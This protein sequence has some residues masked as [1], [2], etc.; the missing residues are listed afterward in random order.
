[1]ISEGIAHGSIRLCDCLPMDLED[2]ICCCGKLW[3]A[4][5]ESESLF[6]FCGCPGRRAHTAGLGNLLLQTQAGLEIAVFVPGAGAEVSAWKGSGLAGFVVGGRDG[7]KGSDWDATSG[8]ESEIAVL[9][10]EGRADR[11]WCWAVGT[12]ER[13][14]CNGGAVAAIEGR[15][16]SRLPIEVHSAWCHLSLAIFSVRLK[17]HVNALSIIYALGQ[18]PAALVSICA[19][20]AGVWQTNCL[21]RH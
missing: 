19:P 9:Y 20:S 21:C 3:M 2:C 14:P 6:L 4:P 5:T 12:L 1:M 17:S 8:G 10:A 11:R 16:V 18:A 15:M 7:G 13:A